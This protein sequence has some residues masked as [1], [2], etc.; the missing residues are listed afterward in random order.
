MEALTVFCQ[1][2]RGKKLWRNYMAF[3]AHVFTGIL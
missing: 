2:E 1:R 3:I